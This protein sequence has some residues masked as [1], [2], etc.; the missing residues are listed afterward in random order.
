MLTMC[1][2]SLSSMVGRVLVLRT[3]RGSFHSSNG[4]ENEGNGSSGFVMQMERRRKLALLL[5]K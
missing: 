5:M 2:V 4:M 1:V 3:A